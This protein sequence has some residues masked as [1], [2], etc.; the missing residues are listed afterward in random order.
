MATSTSINDSF[1]KPP[2]LKAGEFAFWLEQI[3]SHICSLH[4]QM[5]RVVEFGDTKI[6]DTTDP[7]IEKPKERSAYTDADYKVLELN[8]RA[9]KV[10]LMALSPSDQRKV[11][12]YKTAHEIFTAL[13]R[14]YEGN[15][16]IKK[17]RILA[18]TKEYDSAVQGKN[19]SLEEFHSRFQGYVGQ[20]E[21]LGEK[22]PEWKIT[23]QFL[24]ALSSKWDAFSLALQAQSDIKNVTLE[25]LVARLQSNAGVQQRRTNRRETEQS[26]K[27]QSI[28]LKVER[29]FDLAQEDDVADDGDEEV[30]LFTRAFRKVW[31]G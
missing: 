9:K 3:E 6:L 24:Q 28:A 19:E 25:E 22:I 14:M 26:E 16:D 8:M 31:K 21:F 11:L 27:A 18:L 1:W 2:V 17:N 5:W 12:R 13:K 20:L 29:A 4:G 15:D 30:A 7:S 10:L 23:H